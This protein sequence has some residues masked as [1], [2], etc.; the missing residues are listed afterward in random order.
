MSLG[1]GVHEGEG[2]QFP[3]PPLLLFPLLSPLFPPL[4]P[5]SCMH[6]VL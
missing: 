5:F 3:P 2:L 6:G 4:L 1:E